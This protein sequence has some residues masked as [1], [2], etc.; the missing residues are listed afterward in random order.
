MSS[1]SQATGAETD[2]QTGSGAP[3][4]SDKGKRAKKR[5]PSVVVAELEHARWR[6]FGWT[7]FGLLVGGLFLISLGMVGKAFGLALLCVAAF[8]G[9][10][11]AK[12]LLNQAGEIKV[13][14]TG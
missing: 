8:N 1:T 5:P 4:S 6:H 11:F 12:T 7:A 9:R 3:S 10:S 2:A 13:G 14:A